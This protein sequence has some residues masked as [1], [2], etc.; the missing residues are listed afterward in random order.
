MLHEPRHRRSHPASSPLFPP[1]SVH[2]CL[3]YVER[4]ADYHDQPRRLQ[5]LPPLR[6][7]ICRTRGRT[8]THT[9]GAFPPRSTIAY[10]SCCAHNTHLLS[11][12]YTA[13]T[14]TY[15]HVP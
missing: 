9:S 13:T 6:N 2:P 14:H 4:S 11:T 12:I 5:L 10:R 8:P 3:L 1:H 15:F 7:I